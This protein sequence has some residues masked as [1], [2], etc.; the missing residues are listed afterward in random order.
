MNR[1]RS[2]GRDFGPPPIWRL[3]I[4]GL[5]YIVGLVVIIMIILSFLGLR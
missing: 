2:C 4:N 3:F 5:I 1:G